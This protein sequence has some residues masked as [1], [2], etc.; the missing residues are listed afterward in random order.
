MA[1]YT[2]PDGFVANVRAQKGHFEASVLS[3]GPLQCS[4]GVTFDASCRLGDAS[5]DVV[6]FG[7]D[8]SA[9]YAWQANASAAGTAGL[10]IIDALQA[11]GIMGAS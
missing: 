7:G 9:A 2:F 6:G 3:V 4:T 8:E 5:G 11:F 10:G 1:I